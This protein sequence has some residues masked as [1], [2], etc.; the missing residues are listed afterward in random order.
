[1][2]LEIDKPISKK[3]ISI[4]FELK[5]QTINPNTNPYWNRHYT[6]LSGGNEEDPV[7][8]ECYLLPEKEAKHYIT[9]AWKLN[10]ENILT[11]A[12][13]IGKKIIPSSELRVYQRKRF[14]T[15]EQIANIKNLFVA[16]VAVLISVVSIVIGNSKQEPN[17]LPIISAQIESLEASV[18]RK[19]IDEEIIQELR[20]IYETM[21]EISE[22]QLT[23]DD[24]IVLENLERKLE[25]INAYLSEKSSE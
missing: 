7:E 19:T 22:Q 9:Q 3:D 21:S 5:D 20:N 18:N 15:V 8:S 1:M 10:Q 12:E 4:F 6:I 24:L 16:W 13:F 2:I 25:E 23:K 17:Y 14:K 11:Y